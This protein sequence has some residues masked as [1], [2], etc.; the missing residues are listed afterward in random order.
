MK[1]FLLLLM[2][3]VIALAFTACD[4]DDDVMDT[5]L[6]KGQWEVVSQD[7][8]DYSCIYNFTTQ[9]EH[10]WSWGTLTTYYLFP[11]GTPVYDKVYDWHVSDPQN[12]ET[13]Y[14]DITLKGELNADDAWEN[15]DTYIVEKLTKSEM[16]LRKCEAGDT[17]TTLILHRRN[18]LPL[19]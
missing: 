4:D 15:T 10:T 14:L 6:I 3:P 5:K 7:S 11:T 13:V 18:D 19:P 12:Y 17:K 1:K 8:P 2:L 16:V 9:S